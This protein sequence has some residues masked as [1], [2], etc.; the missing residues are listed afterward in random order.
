VWY[1]VVG[2]VADGRVTQFD[3]DALR[4]EPA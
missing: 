2:G 3:K 4:V 1:S